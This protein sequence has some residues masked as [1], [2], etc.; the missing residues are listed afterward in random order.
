MQ[1]EKTEMK[2]KEGLRS[3]VNHINKEYYV[4]DIMHLSRHTPI[5]WMD[6]KLLDHILH[7]IHQLN[8]DRIDDAKTVYP[9]IVVYNKRYG[10]VVLDGMHR[11]SKVIQQGRR[12]IMARL[13]KEDDL[14]RLPKA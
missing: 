1:K 4:D 11:L 6:V 9:I 14:K 5:R 2:Y 10:Y 8:Q 3:T 7:G 12:K 13:I